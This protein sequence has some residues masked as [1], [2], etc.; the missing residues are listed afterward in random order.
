M[1]AWCL[2]GYFGLANLSHSWG[3]WLAVVGLGF[4]GGCFGPLNTVAMP[5]FFGRKHLGAIQ[6]TLL[7][8]LVIA[9]ALG[10][11]ILSLLR[12]ATGS[13]SNSLLFFLVLPAA[14][15]VVS[16]FVKRPEE[17]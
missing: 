16:F 14:G 12:D 6:G 15:V 4:G 5:K 13:F 2:L 3:Y 10:P 9:S 1:A 7:S 8:F 17:Y 11:I